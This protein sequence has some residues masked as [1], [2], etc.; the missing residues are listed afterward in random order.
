MFLNKEQKQLRDTGL[1]KNLRNCQ[2][3]HYKDVLASEWKPAIVLRWGHGYTY[4]SAGNEKTW[5]P[6]ELIKIRSEQR[7]PLNSWDLNVFI[8]S[9]SESLSQTVS[10]TNFSKICVQINIK[11]ASPTSGSHKGRTTHRPKRQQ[12][13]WITQR[14]MKETDINQQV[15]RCWGR[16]ER[17]SR[18][19]VKER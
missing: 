14:Q 13:D 4:V 9:Q 6:T 2:P 11:R 18:P 16:R 3:L 7:K 19:G 15:E 17:R 10:V 1:W 12:R 8:Q 5:L